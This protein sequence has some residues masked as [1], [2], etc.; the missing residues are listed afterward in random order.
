M[1][2]GVFRQH[3]MMDG[4]IVARII[5]ACLSSR[6]TPKEIKDLIVAHGWVDAVDE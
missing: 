1:E 5:R 3:D 6:H 4:A 2:S